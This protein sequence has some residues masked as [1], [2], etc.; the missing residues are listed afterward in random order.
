MKV[1]QN[2]RIEVKLLATLE[3]LL[4][5]FASAVARAVCRVAVEL[6][7]TLSRHR[8]PACPRSLGAGE[9]GGVHEAGVALSLS[10]PGG[11]VPYA[12]LRG[13]FAI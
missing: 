8:V 6:V 9:D 2:R 12:T 10:K 5:A 4:S 1:P 7:E 3:Y 13:C 11:V